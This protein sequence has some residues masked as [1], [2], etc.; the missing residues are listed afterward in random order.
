MIECMNDDVRDALPDLIHGRLSSLDR[1]TLTDHV[2]GCSA[3][4][5][6]LTL[7]REIRATAPLA[8]AIDIERVVA[9]LPAP[10]AVHTLALQAAGAFSRETPVRDSFADPYFG[11]RVRW[12]VAAGVLVAAVGFSVVIGNREGGIRDR[13]VA[14][15][16]VG[17]GTSEPAALLSPGALPSAVASARSSAESQVAVRPI[18]PAAAVALTLVGGVNE[19]SDAHIE[20]LLSEMDEME[21]IP[22]SEPESATL[23][24]ENLEG[25]A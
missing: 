19:L 10:S 1:A 15:V 5:D 2:E 3:C 6:E 22:P 4:S 8:P 25:E 14:R 17:D 18:G 20:R 23:L 7:L 16:P 9:A 24:L 12:A 13:F 11:G 21:G